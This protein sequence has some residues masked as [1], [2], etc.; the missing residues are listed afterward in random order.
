MNTTLQA[1]LTTITPLLL[2]ALGALA[3]WALKK[4]QKNQAAAEDEKENA[5]EDAFSWA[6]EMLEPIIFGLVTKAERELGDGVGRLKLATVLDQ[7]LAVL[8]EN[9]KIL[10]SSEWIIHR[11]EVALDKAK[12]LW[13]ENPALVQSVGVAVQGVPLVTFTREFAE[14][15]DEP[16]GDDE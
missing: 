2:A 8:P 4:W 6:E 16:A 1:L 14:A 3:L 11:I 7:V 5:A 10:V 12:T 15:E 9:V 13:A